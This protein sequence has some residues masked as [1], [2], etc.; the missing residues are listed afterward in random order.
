MNLRKDHYRSFTLTLCV[1]HFVRSCEGTP[2]CVFRVAH[3]MV[4]VPFLD[5]HTAAAVCCP[6]QFAFAFCKFVLHGSQFA[7]CLTQRVR[8]R[9]HM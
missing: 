2:A 6:L 7:M 4:V 5:L 9:R 1:L 3:N 8:F